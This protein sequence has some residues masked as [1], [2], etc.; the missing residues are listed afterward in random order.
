V[1]IPR[2]TVVVAALAVI[3]FY[4]IKARYE[5]RLLLA[6]FPGYEAYRKRTLGVLMTK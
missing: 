5:D 4:V 3:I 1:T 6:H 2:L